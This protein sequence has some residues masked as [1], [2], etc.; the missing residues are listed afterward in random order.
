MEETKKRKSCGKELLNYAKFCNDCGTKFKKPIYERWWFWAIA[1]VLFVGIV[2]AASEGED[3][4]GKIRS[5]SAE[6]PK[7]TPTPSPTVKPTVELT[8][9]PVKNKEMS[10]DYLCALIKKTM[11]DDYTG[12]TVTHDENIITISIWQEGVV[13]ELSV[14]GEES[15]KQ[16]NFVKESML[17]LS[18]SIWGVIDA[19]GREDISL[20]LNVLNDVNQENMLLSIMEGI[21]IYDVMKD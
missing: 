5:W 21:I 3:D 9:E 17:N 15:E 2:E 1:A 14:G 10:L 8:V 16:W 12:C 20:L 19:A 18:D 13:L 4:S 6:T 11:G 7:P